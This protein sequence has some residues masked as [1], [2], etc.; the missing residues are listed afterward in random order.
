[1]NNE[2]GSVTL[3]MVGMVLIVFAVGGIALDLWR[4]LT[5]YRQVSALVDS[6]AVAAGSGLDESAWRVE[7]RLVLDPALVQARVAESIAAQSGDTIGHDVVVAADGSEA[8]VRAW[9]SVDLTLLR[10]VTGGSIEVQARATA[11][12][13]LSP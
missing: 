11:S 13:T 2:R 7:G 8:T 5:A 4:G 12:P 1:M 10:L 3:W 9:T 6:A